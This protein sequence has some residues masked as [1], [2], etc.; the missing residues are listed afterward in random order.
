MLQI[1]RSRL[2]RNIALMSSATMAAQMINVFTQPIL[3]RIVPAETLG[4][5]TYLVSMANIA[6]PIASLKLDLLITSEKDENLAQYIT[7][8]CVVITFFVSVCFFVVIGCGYYLRA[9]VFYQYGPLIFTVP[10]MVFTNGIRFLFISYNNR[11]RQYKII[12][13]IG[14]LRELTRGTIQVIS[15]LCSF[16]VVGQVAGFALAPISGLRRQTKDYIVNFQDRKYLDYVV[17][18][19]VIA[20]GKKQILYLVPS[21]F[22]NSFASS[23]VILFISLLYSNEHLGYYSAGVRLLEV[24][25]IFIAANVSKVLY[26]QISED[27]NLSRNVLS[28]FV[29]T[30]ILLFSI[31]AISFGALYVIAPQFSRFVFGNGYGTAG[32]YIK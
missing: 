32:E 1:F 29:K 22:L 4:V 3:T 28:K 10:L 17:F 9:Q 26:K 5:Y 2:F 14:I 6:I 19:H 25:M 30:S 20:M 12:G 11:Y 23:L 16:G 13:F 18:R 31:S 24:P 15:G 8:V 7:D 27:V 21:Q